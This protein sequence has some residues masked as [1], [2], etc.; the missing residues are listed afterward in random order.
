MRHHRCCHPAQHQH[1]AQGCSIHPQVGR[2]LG[3][4]YLDAAGVLTQR[5]GPIGQ[6]PLHAHA[7]MG[8]LYPGLWTTA[9]SALLA[10]QARGQ[11]AA[12][13]WH[14]LWGGAQEEGPPTPGLGLGLGR[15]P[16]A[17]AGV[18]QQERCHQKQRMKSAAG[19]LMTCVR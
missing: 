17:Q 15:W 7:R 12:W 11:V 5:V 4:Q 13:R 8:V 10:S 9:V 1:Y 2:Q 18:G 3:Q 16:A 14:G 6:G 19:G